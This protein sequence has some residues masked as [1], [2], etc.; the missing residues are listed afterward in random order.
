MQAP[1]PLAAKLTLDSSVFVTSTLSSAPLAT[2]SVK[3]PAVSGA[4]KPSKI[5]FSWPVRPVRAL[6]I[7]SSTSARPS[8]RGI[9]L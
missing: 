6:L 1:A 3:C 7:V 9:S 4:L 5:A 8:S 2:K